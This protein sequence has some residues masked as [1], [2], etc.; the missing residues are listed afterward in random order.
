MAEEIKIDS[1][2]FFKRASSILASFKDAGSPEDERLNRCDAV[3]VL[4]GGQN[5]EVTYSKT[6]SLHTWLLGYEFPSTLIVFTKESI[7]FVTS[8]TKAKYLEPFVSNKEGIKVE[9]LKRSKNDDENKAI[10]NDVIKKITD[11]GKRIGSFTKETQIGKV[12]DEWKAALEEARAK[13]GLEEVDVG[14]AFSA[15]WASKDEEEQKYLKTASRMSSGI[16][17]KYFVDEMSTTLDDDKKVSHEKLAARVEDKLEDKA[18]W[19]KVRNLESADLSLADWCYTPII[20]S[21]GVYDLRTSAQSN[22][23][24]LEGANG[25]GVILASMGLKYKSYCSNIG[26]TWLIDPHKTQQKTYTTLI[27]LQHEIAEKFLRAGETCKS[28][29]D[30]AVESLRAKNS[31][32][33][34]H[35]TK[36]IG[37]AT[38][39]EFRDSTFVLWP[40][41]TR[42]I[43]QDMVFNLVV[44]FDGLDD[45]AHPGKKYSL[46]VIDTVRVTNGAAVFLTDRV[47]AAS[48]SIFLKDDSDEDEKADAKSSTKKKQAHVDG[49][50]AGGKVL[51]NR[52]RTD[53]MDTNSADKFAKHQKELAIQKQ[54]DGLS[55]FADQDGEGSEERGK[56]FKKFESYKKDHMV[57]NKTADLRIFID[58]KAQTIFLPIYG[59][60]V[61]FHINTLKNVSKSDEGDYT[62]LRFNFIAPGQIAGKKED[63]PFENP[64]ATFVRSMS[65]RSSETSHFSELYHDISELKKLKTKEEAEKK[66]LADVVEQDKIVLNKGRVQTLSDVFPRPALEGK[67]VPG[68]LEIHQNGLRFASPIRPDQKIDVLFN[69][70]KHLFYQPCDN[71]LIVLI[72][73]HLK[74]PIM[75]GKKK[76]KDVQFYREA[77]DVQFDETGNR[78]RK[79]RGGDEDEIELEQ[80]ERRQRH[81]L[82]KEFKSFASKISDASEGRLTVDTPFRELG[83]N[84]VPHR[85][86]V[87]LQPTTECLVH[88]TDPPFFVTTLSEIEIVHLERVSYGLKNFDMVIINSDFSQAPVHINS[89]DVKNLDAIKEYLDSCDICVSEGPVNLN[90]PQI[91]TQ[92]KQD[93]YGFFE[94]GGWSFL[95]TESDSEDND[96]DAS[97]S[98]SDFGNEVG[99]SDVFDDESSEDEESDFDEESDEGSGSD[100]DEDESE[101]EDWDELERKAKR[102]DDKKRDDASSDED[103]KG[104]KKGGGKRR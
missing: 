76:T 55:R 41:N 96:E 13:E 26:R 39:L 86:N 5:E 98:G 31:S 43:K 99:E 77:S 51:R 78:K 8:A 79:Y 104:R 74:A 46:L 32:L 69:N 94:D 95:S 85:N 93:P 44:G 7:I 36:N 35:L 72:H 40:K 53:A 24:R 17:S 102:A 12:A 19:K 75:V 100:F 84:G 47:A 52:T 90:W 2:A 89:I 97:A 71:E 65:F 101:G 92:I 59:F 62:Y 11:Q 21:G 20:Q 68:G 22:S 73:V 103:R 1:K 33:V 83:F 23:N 57:P 30:Q 6:L 16:M 48:E 56:T 63:V 15:I 34:D 81:I 49:L 60:S 10:W 82:N 29:Y 37:F 50:E 58:H 25:G 27:E 14:A 9:I 80:E 42:K 67:R 28:V 3:S 87:L 66:E 45:P 4:M 61:P 18:L 38:G 70:V 91:L 54:E 64:D 88:L